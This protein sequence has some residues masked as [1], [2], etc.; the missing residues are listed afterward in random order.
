VNDCSGKQQLVPNLH[1]ACKLCNRIG[2]KDGISSDDIEYLEAVQGL[3]LD[4]KLLNKFVP[5]W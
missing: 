2:G 5:N 1:N 4:E 3:P